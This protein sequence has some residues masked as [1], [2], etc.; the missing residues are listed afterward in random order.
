MDLSSATAHFDSILSEHLSLID[1]GSD[2]GKA[3]LW[4]LQGG[5]RL[6][7]ALMY[8]IKG[9]LK[10]SLSID[11]AA[12]SIE[13]I[14]TSSLIADDLPS[15]DNDTIRRGQKTTHIKFSE[16]T[17]YLA[18]Y[19]LIALGYQ[20]LAQCGHSLAVIYPED[21]HARHLKA[22][23]ILCS[24]SMEMASGQFYDLQ[25]EKAI[26]QKELMRLKTA[27]LFQAAFTIAWLLCG[28]SIDKIALVEEAALCF[29][30]AFQLADDLIDAKEDQIHGNANWTSTYS[31]ASAIGEF[32]SHME[33]AEK[34]LDALGLLN[35]HFK[36]LLNTLYNSVSCSSSLAS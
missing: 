23:E 16:S 14:H 34:H 2:V 25:V 27:S 4:A 21:G 8:L 26:T 13:M 1:E 28:G 6:R 24:K 35:K 29:G 9:A 36:A 11:N 15:M 5:K 3:A 19:R 10:S 33:K 20:L 30:I 22:L 17:A 12:L 32:K 7:P 18:S 31:E